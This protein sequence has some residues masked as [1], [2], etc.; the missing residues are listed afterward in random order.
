M[1]QS[2]KQEEEEE[3]NCANSISVFYQRFLQR[4]RRGVTWL[5]RG[6]MNELTDT[7]CWPVGWT[8]WW[9]K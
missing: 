1:V 9:R 8:W 7:G 3:K 6:C 4:I 5:E 2:V